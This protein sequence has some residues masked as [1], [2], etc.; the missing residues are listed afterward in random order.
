MTGELLQAR[1]PLIDDWTLLTGFASIFDDAVEVVHFELEITATSVNLQSWIWLLEGLSLLLEDKEGAFKCSLEDSPS[2]MD[3]EKES[4]LSI[5]S[6]V[7][8]QG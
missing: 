4:F 3:D 1:W 5:V 7:N 6:H 2:L 8:V